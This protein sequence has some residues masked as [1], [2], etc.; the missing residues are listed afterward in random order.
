MDRSDPK[1]DPRPAA[2]REKQRTIIEARDRR[3]RL[4]GIDPDNAN[5]PPGDRRVDVV[6]SI[7]EKY[8]AE[9][10]K[11]NEK[12]IQQARDDNQEA[13]HIRDEPAI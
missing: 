8:A 11:V 3:M 6:L 13:R 12:F 9:L 1:I 7:Q 4:A 5:F 10:E 2:L